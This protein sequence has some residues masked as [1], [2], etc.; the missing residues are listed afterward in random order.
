[1]VGV[2]CRERTLS[3]NPPSSPPLSPQLQSPQKTAQTRVHRVRRRPHRRRR[4][5]RRVRARAGRRRVGRQRHLPLGSAV[6]S[7]GLRC[8]LWRWRR[9]PAGPP[10]QVAGQAR[11]GRRGCAVRARP[12]RRLVQALRPHQHGGLAQDCQK[13]WQSHGRHRVGRHSA[14]LLERGAWRSAVFILPSPHRTARRGSPCSSPPKIGWTPWPPPGGRGEAAPGRC[15]AAGGA[16]RFGAAAAARRHCRHRSRLQRRGRGDRARSLP[17]HLPSETEDEDDDESDAAVRGV[18]PTP[19]VACAAFSEDDAL[20]E[21]DDD[22]DDED[23]T[24]PVGTAPGRNSSSL[25]PRERGTPRPATASTLPSLPSPFSR[26]RPTLA[27]GAGPS[28][29]SSAGAGPSTASSAGTGQLSTASTVGAGPMK[30]RP[31]AA[32]AA[33]SALDAARSDGGMFPGVTS[34]SGGS[35]GDGGSASTPPSSAAGGGG[36]PSSPAARSAAAPALGRRHHRVRRPHPRVSGVSH[37]HRVRP[38]VWPA[39]GA[40]RVE[41]RR[42]RR[43]LHY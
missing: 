40:A 37:R 38:A 3:S 41:D 42:L 36:P 21:D 33:A 43:T 6:H 24:T 14:E 31:P 39:H 10:A 23:I 4:R 34:G 28:T 8:R 19:H 35:G 7:G 15:H 11:R 29:A 9:Q 16:A 27:A 22:D 12:A 32:L 20:F 17:C 18:S 2:E 30:V 13:V 1:M 26:L 25:W 5:T